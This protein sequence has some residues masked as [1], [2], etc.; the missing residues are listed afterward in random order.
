MSKLC[1]GI[2]VILFCFSMALIAT[3]TQA[4]QSVTDQWVTT[5][6][7]KPYDVIKGVD[8]YDHDVCIA[9]HKNRCIETVCLYSEYTDCTQRCEKLSIYKC[10]VILNQ[11]Y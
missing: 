8:T 7:I 5:Q 2:N 6:T 1:F 10:E 3:P 9:V 11:G 4:L